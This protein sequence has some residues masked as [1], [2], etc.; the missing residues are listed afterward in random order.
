M[1]DNSIDRFYEKL[2]E[3]ENKRD[4]AEELADKIYG[5]NDNN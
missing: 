3:L 5:K 2:T 1:S 4:K